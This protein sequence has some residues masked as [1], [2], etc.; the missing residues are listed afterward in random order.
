MAN[1]LTGD[2]DVVAE[3]AVLTV[4]RLLATMHQTGR[5]LHSISIRVD[6]N[7]RPQRPGWPVIVGAVDGFGDAIANQRQIGRP[8]PFPSA[9]TVAS[10]AFAHLGTLLNPDQLVNVL[11]PFTPSHISGVAQLQLFPPTIANPQSDSTNLTVRMNLICRFFPDKGTAPLAEFIRGDLQITAPMNKIVSGKINVLDI[12]FKAEDAVIS[13]TPSYTSNPLSA[14]DLAGIN[15]CIQN[16]LQT[17]FLPSSVT[18]PNTIADVQLKTLPGALV[19]MLDLNDH[20]ST[21]SSVN[22]VFLDFGNDDFAIAVGRDYLLN[23]LRMVSDNVLSQGFA[24]VQFSVDLSLWGIGETLHYDYPIQVS[25]ASFDLQPGNI[26][27]TINGSAGPETHGHP[28]SS[29]NFT[30]TVQFSLQASGPDVSL[31]LGDVSVSTSSTLAGIVDFFTGDITDAV[32]NAVTTAIS[33]TGVGAM[34]SAMF[35]ANTNLGNSLNSQLNP[36][37]G[38]AQIQSQQLFLIYNSVDIQAAGVVLHGSLLVFDWPA[39]YVEFEPIPPS[40]G[41]GGIISPIQGTDYSALK[42]WIP[43]GTIGEYEWSMQ[44]QSGPFDIDHN[45]FVLL[46]SGQVVA[47]PVAAAA[48]AI[49]LPGYSPLCLTITGNRISNYGTPAVYQNVSASICGYTRFPLLPGIEI[50][51]ANLAL[52]V[53]ITRPSP[54]GGL[55][56]SGEVAAAVDPAGGAAPNLVVHYADSAS[57]AQLQFLTQAISKSH[58]KSAPTAAVA[59]LTPDQLAKAP[60]TTG[61]VYGVDH[62]GSWAKAFKIKSTKRPLTLIVAPGGKI[63][64]ESEGPINADVLAKALTRHLIKRS[65]VKLSLPRLN[66]RIGQPAPNF[67]FEYA[68]GREM[69]LSKLSGQP[70]ILIFWRSTVKSSIT[71]VRNLQVFTAKSTVATK[72][73]S[74]L[75]TNSATPVVLAINDG[76]D[77]QVARAA[78]A[79]SGI[80]AI[81]VTDPKREISQGYGVNMWPTIVSL[82]QNGLIAGIK[83]GYLPGEPSDSPSQTKKA[84]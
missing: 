82:D 59:V 45:R 10:A 34:V 21:A 36:T 16:G 39:P 5:F 58:H 31:I 69:P 55:V 77:P 26:V 50:G 43:G 57:S 32:R 54:T 24:P 68:S 84:S 8:N 6:D 64:W 13:F 66:V 22:N 53:A 20:P 81:L 62:D 25:T 46:H 48:A 27:L 65:P 19:V 15:L 40:A 60:Y 56:V 52:T 67:L 23:T 33:S 18:L 17:S 74:V 79:E 49:A 70:I 42:T 1:I 80:T 75:K 47:E 9:A 11:P 35:N 63:V 78:A 3:F 4:D 71:A 38:S 41:I 61:I 76:E 28:P 29:F 44:G 72:V 30:V 2:F 83:Y 37:D 7:P 12:D 51:A 14:E 73:R